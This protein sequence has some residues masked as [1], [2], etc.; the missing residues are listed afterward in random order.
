MGR[1]AFQTEDR[2]QFHSSFSTSSLKITY[3]CCSLAVSGGTY[4]RVISNRCPLLS[5]LSRALYLSICY[6]R[7]IC[8]VVLTRAIGGDQDE[9]FQKKLG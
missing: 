1:K 8:K 9:G 3:L 4:S 5:S 7:K 6:R 2:Q